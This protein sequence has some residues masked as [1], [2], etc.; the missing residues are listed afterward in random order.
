MMLP[1]RQAALVVDALEGMRYH[2]DMAAVHLW[3]EV[4]FRIIEDSLN[5][6]WKVDTAML[7]ETLTS[8]SKRE[9]R[10][11]L[12][13]VHL[14]LEAAPHTNIWHALVEHELTDHEPA[15]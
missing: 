2:E 3:V 14:Y 13:K 6:K 7:M 10:D 4:N 11:Y 15:D 1:P 8:M 5:T 12:E 9:A